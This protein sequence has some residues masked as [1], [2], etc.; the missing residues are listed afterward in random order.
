MGK[1]SQKLKLL[2]IAQI[3]LSQSD[4]EHPVSTAGLI[5]QLESQGI[6]AERKSVYA[7]LEVLRAAG[8]DI[9]SRKGKSAGHFVQQRQFELAELKLLVD[10]VQ[11]SRCISEKKSIQLIKKLQSLASVHQAKRLWRHVFVSGRAKTSNETLFYNIDALHD[12]ID[13]AQ[14][15]SFSYYEYATDKTLRPK[16]S[17]QRYVV[18]PYLLCWNDQNYYLVAYH[19]RYHGLS[20]FRVD[21]MKDILCTGEPVQKNEISPGAYASRTFDMF[22]GDP[23]RVEIDIPSARIGAI[24]DRFGKGIFTAPLGND[25]LAVT[26]DVAVSPAFFSWLFMLGDVYITHP[27]G[28]KQQYVKMLGNTLSRQE[29]A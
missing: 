17:G 5:A 9:V 29:K 25:R 27:E 11:S 16:R 18:S 26:L 2:S 1:D 7:D 19:E 22:A 28:V 20:H 4:D 15:I 14:K 12:A 21:K 23:E 10:A 6:S 24:I 8:M 13:A 3:L